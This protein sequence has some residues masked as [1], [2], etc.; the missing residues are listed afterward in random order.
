MLQ[1]SHASKTGKKKPI[2]GKKFQYLNV[3]TSSKDHSLKLWGMPWA[4]GGEDAAAEPPRLIATIPGSSSAE[5]LGLATKGN[6]RVLLCGDWNG[7][8]RA[9]SVPSD[10]RLFDVENA[11]QDA[12]DLTKRRRIASGAVPGQTQTSPSP[13]LLFS[14]KAHSQTLTGIDSGEEGASLFTSS[15]DHSLK[16][17]DFERQDC[18]AS[19]I[20]PKV[21]TSL[22]R[23]PGQASG[24]VVATSHP[25]GKVRL[26][27]ARRASG[28]GVGDL[29]TPTASFGV[30]SSS[31]WISTVRWRPDSEFLFA[32]SDHAGRV[33][34]W[35]C[36]AAAAPLLVHETHP[37]SRALCLDW[38][39]LRSNGG[40]ST[41][42][43]G[44]GAAAGNRSSRRAGK[45]GI[46]IERVER[47]GL[48]DASRIMLLSGGSDC[49]LRATPLSGTY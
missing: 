17:W 5:S 18:L 2:H 43:E 33:A 49:H 9:F 39:C 27:D 44:V 25:D 3:V 40:T 14:I 26:W 4:E 13:P 32:T 28:E 30:S 48:S 8:L 12:D 22:H 29:S 45:E 36:R 1:A 41:M 21:V 46:Q 38:L 16:L 35:D 7:L 11:E 47:K 19:F 34:L 15:W 42:A 37:G 23:R 24:N 10:L 6:D 31:S 20:S